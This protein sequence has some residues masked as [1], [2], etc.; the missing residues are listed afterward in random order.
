MF[1]NNVLP[2]FIRLDQGTIRSSP[3]RRY[4]SGPTH[5]KDLK[6]IKAIM[7]LQCCFFWTLKLYLKT[8]LTT[9]MKQRSGGGG[10]AFQTDM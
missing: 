6:T 7:I 2:K 5:I 9:S 1:Q 3:V 8:S 4:G 10:K